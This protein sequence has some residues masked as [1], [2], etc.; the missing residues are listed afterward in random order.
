MTTA[1]ELWPPY[2]LSLRPSSCLRHFFNSYN[3]SCRRHNVKRSAISRQFANIP[4]SVHQIT[5]RAHVT[6]MSRPLSVEPS[7][8]H[9]QRTAL[10]C[11]RENCPT[12]HINGPSVEPP[13]LCPMDRNPYKRHINER[14]IKTSAML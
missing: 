3:N 13:R 10:W 7:A 2:S 12:D 9:V 5:R 4:Y 6:S 11:V 8:R 1:E 14:F